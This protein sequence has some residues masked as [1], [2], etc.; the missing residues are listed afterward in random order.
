VQQRGA[1]PAPSDSLTI[2]LSPVSEQQAD[3]NAR[4]IATGAVAAIAPTGPSLQRKL[5]VKKPGKAIPNPGGKGLKQTNAATV[6]NYLGELCHVGS[7]KVDAGTGEVTISSSFCKPVTLPPDFVG[8]PAPS[9]KDSDT[10]VG[11]GCICDI[12]ASKNVWTIEVNDSR[13]PITKPGDVDAAIG[14]KAGGTG[15]VVTVPS[16]NSDKIWGAATA[17][18]TELDIDPWLVL[19]HELCGHAWMMNTGSHKADS[20]TPRGEG[21][22]QETVKRENLLRG[23]HG[24]DPRGSFKDPNC[25]E[26]YFRDKAAPGT[27]NWS[28]F[29]SVCEQWRKDYNAKHGT[30]YKITDKI[31]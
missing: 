8:P 31:P 20:S 1:V 11:C 7:P 18:G 21:G 26:S 13:W 12:V 29:H 23:E 15:G 27:V 3:D 5:Q 10:P 14:N 6:Q 17:K 2:D 19:G 28:D 16:P 4:L 24:I 9:V 30:N 22:H 25:G